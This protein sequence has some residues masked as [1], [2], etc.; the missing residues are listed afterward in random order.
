M[1]AAIP[2]DWARLGRPFPVEVLDRAVGVL[3]ELRSSL[4]GEL[5]N[6]DLHY[7]NVLA[8]ERE[9]WLAIDPKVVQ[10]DLEYGVAPLIW[11]PHAQVDSRRDLDR[12]L[13][14]VVSAGELDME[15]T[16]GWAYVRIIEYWLWGLEAGLTHDPAKCR[17][18][19]EWL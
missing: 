17:A 15:R 13:A 4:K 8:G 14:S 10:G 19:A 3:N 11:S 12:R 18:L 6:T 5:V 7:G 9:P 16:R 2:A 1:A